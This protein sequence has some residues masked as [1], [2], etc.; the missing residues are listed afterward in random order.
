MK[1]LAKALFALA[2]LL[3]ASGCYLPARFDAEITLDRAGYYSMVF[4]GYLAYLPLYQDLKDKKISPAE[5]KEQ[6]ELLRTDLTRDS[7]VSEFQYFKMGHFKVHWEKK[8]DLLR[9]KMVTF[10]RRNADMLSLSYVRDKREITIRGAY[11]RKDQQKQLEEIGLNVQGQI[12]VITEARVVQ[13]NATKVTK[14]DGKPMYVWDIAN[15][16]SPAPRMVIVP[17]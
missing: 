11:L 14:R 3:T 7:S 13:H 6:V 16:R 10:F 15:V 9:T 5:E 2:A 17:G 12:R 8:G 1:P 4:D